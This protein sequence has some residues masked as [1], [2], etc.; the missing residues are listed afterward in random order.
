MLVTIDMAAAKLAYNVIWGASSWEVI[1]NSGPFH[2]MCSHMDAVVRMTSGSG[3]ED[4]AGLCASD[5]IEQVML[6]KHYNRSVRVY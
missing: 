4:S 3:F 6:G 2:T 5:S 1:V